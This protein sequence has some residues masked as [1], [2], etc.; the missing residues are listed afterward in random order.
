MPISSDFVDLLRALN[1]AEAEFLVVGA[2]AVAYYAEPRYTKDLDLWVGSTPENARRVYRA[3]AAFGAPL[4]DLKETD[5]LDP[6]VVYQIG[7]EPVRADIL[8]GME[9]L[10]FETAWRDSEQTTFGGQNVR[11]IGL[12]HL[13]ALKRRAGRPQDRLDVAVLERV[14]ARRHSSS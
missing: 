8:A 10:N 3:L 2:Y 5:L 7:I 9:G 14:V 11:V 12:K 6:T 4:N 13:I 1:D